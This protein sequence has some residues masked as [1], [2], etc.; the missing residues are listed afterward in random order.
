MD[1]AIFS[2]IQ[3]LVG[4]VLTY[5]IQKTQLFTALNSGLEQS[6]IRS[7]YCLIHGTK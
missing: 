5:L 2:L 4:G 7:I 3:L 6:K 1:V